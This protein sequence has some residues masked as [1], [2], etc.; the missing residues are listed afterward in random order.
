MVDWPTS[1]AFAETPN[2]VYIR[3]IT[4]EDKNVEI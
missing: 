3:G 2:N 4:I 1:R